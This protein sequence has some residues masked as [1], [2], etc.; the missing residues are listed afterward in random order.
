MFDLSSR[1][2]SWASTDETRDAARLAAKVRA[3]LPPYYAALYCIYGLVSG[4][5]ESSLC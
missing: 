4:F 5:L 1:V 3:L 2:P